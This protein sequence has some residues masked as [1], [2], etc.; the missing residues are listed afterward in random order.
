M[1]FI[2]S[3]KKAGKIPSSLFLK[4]E[5][6]CKWETR[7]L[8]E[9]MFEEEEDSLEEMMLGPVE[10]LNHRLKQLTDA[11]IC[12]STQSRV[13]EVIS[14]VS[15]K[16]GAVLCPS[17]DGAVLASHACVVDLG[18]PALVQ[19]HIKVV[20]EVLN[21][22]CHTVYAA[23][24]VTHQSWLGQ[25][26][27]MISQHRTLLP[28]L[29]TRLLTLFSTENTS[30][31]Q[32]HIV[33]IA[34]FIVHLANHVTLFPP[35]VVKKHNGELSQ[36]TSFLSLFLQSLPVSTGKEMVETL[37]FLAEYLQLVFLGL[38][39]GMIDYSKLKAVLPQQLIV[40]TYVLCWRVFPWTQPS[41]WSE[42]S[43]PHS[44]HSSQA[45]NK[46]TEFA[47]KLDHCESVVAV[48]FASEKFQEVMNVNGPTLEDWLHHELGVSPAMDLL[49][50]QQRHI[51]HQTMMSHFIWNCSNASTSIHSNHCSSLQ[52]SCALFM[53]VLVKAMS[54]SELKAGRCSVCQQ[55]VHVSP[56]DTHINSHAV[57]QLL[58]LFTKLVQSILPADL[59]KEEEPWLVHQVFRL[60]QLNAGN[61]GTFTPEAVLRVV[62]GCPA[63]LL[64][65][66]CA[67]L[68]GK[69]MV[70]TVKLL[71]EFL[72]NS[73]AE[74]GVLSLDVICHVLQGYIAGARDCSERK[75]MEM[76]ENHPLIILSSLVH[77]QSLCTLLPA[78]PTYAPWDKLSCVLDMWDRLSA[79][80]RQS[81]PLSDTEPFHLAA[82]L[83]SSKINRNLS[84]NSET[85]KQFL[86]CL[87]DAEA[88]HCL[89]S[90]LIVSLSDRVI[91]CA[92][93]PP[94][95]EIRL[96]WLSELWG[97]FPHLISLTLNNESGFSFPGRSLMSAD[98]E[99]FSEIACL[100]CVSSLKTEKI[101]GEK[102]VVHKVLS[103]YA[104]L[105]QR[106]QDESPKQ[107]ADVSLMLTFPKTAVTLLKM[108]PLA[109]LQS[110]SQDDVKHCG[111][112]AHRI[113]Q[114]RLKNRL[115]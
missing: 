69:S 29:I 63:Y 9:G 110:V 64:F 106:F 2:E 87:Q 49:S 34:A 6:A 5:E 27:Q 115:E 51:F 7:Q 52:E 35:V 58:S 40:M 85:R 108:L 94:K 24:D 114:Q 61:A 72:V 43:A 100:R 67:R 44:C 112:E 47:T 98:L 86:Q 45:R 71:E 83:Y 8:L 90:V 28:D 22:V 56:S 95:M 113:Y 75:A 84:C 70:C 99:P 41:Q 38:R 81:L 91:C 68:S 11:V 16:I 82:S 107:G 65:T 3:L 79:E 104:R 36:D 33:G 46:E 21:C 73:A 102:D 74:H 80:G 76:F 15:E 42:I 93:L 109:V 32:H 53:E 101:M 111:L 96:Q 97:L 12:Q 20:D 105:C 39:S 62:L 78:L 59:N 89:S 31:S 13:A 26:V 14:I 77:W 60:L 57:D 66:S 4:Y 18:H 17:P 55:T 92:S 1:K 23:L 30:L 19:S 54:R 10:Q 103:L 48:L 50:S 25:L 88:L 37:R